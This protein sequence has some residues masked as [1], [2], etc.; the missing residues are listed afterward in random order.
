MADRRM[1]LARVAGQELLDLAGQRADGDDVVPVP[2]RVGGG[3]HEHA[4]LAEDQ[5]RVPPLAGQRVRLDP[6]PIPGQRGEPTL[7]L[8][9][10]QLETPA[11]VHVAA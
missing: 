11:K 4:R 8:G 1:D 10:G 5:Q 3:D 7:E 6:P 2:G 9:D